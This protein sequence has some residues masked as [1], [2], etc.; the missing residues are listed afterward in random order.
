[1]PKKNLAFDEKGPKRIELSWKIFW[2][3]FTVSFDGQEIGRMNGR[4]ELTAGWEFDLPDGTVLT[5]R[6]VNRFLSPE[7][8]V[9]RNGEPLPGSGSDPNQKVK[10][11]S[12]II[13]FIGGLNTILSLVSIGS[14]SVFLTGMGIG[15]ASLAFG[16]VF[17]LLGF[18]VL[19]RSAVALILAL[20]LLALDALFGM[21]AGISGSG[22]M[23]AGGLVMRIFFIIFIYQGLAAIRDIKKKSSAM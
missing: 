22:R 15:Y 20:V 8:Q 4:Q 23:P 12:G 16:C 9:L 7:L 14:K 2:K 21:Y 5:V 11:A 17:L 18:F 1:M 19:K 3:D 10:I 6:L 13:F